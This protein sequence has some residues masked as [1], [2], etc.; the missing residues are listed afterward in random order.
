MASLTFPWWSAIHMNLVRLLRL[1]LLAA[2]PLVVFDF[3]CDRSP[4]PDSSGFHQGA[5]APAWFEDVTDKVGLDFVHDAGPTGNYFMPQVFGSGAA[6]FFDPHGRLYLYLLTN[7]GPESPSTNRLYRRRK[8]GTFEDVTAGSGLGIAG[9]NMGVAVGDVNNDGWPDVVVTQYGGLKLFLN[10]RDGTFR[11]VPAAESGLENP[12][13]ATSAAFADIDRDGWLDLVVVNYLDYDPEVPCHTAT[14]QRDFCLPGG[15]RGRVTKLFRNNG[16]KASGKKN[17]KLFQDITVSAGLADKPGPGLG[18]ICADFNGDGWP[19]IFVANDA[20]ANYLWIN[21]GK[22]THFSEEALTRGVALNASGQAQGNMGVALG[23]VDGDHLLDLFVTHFRT[24]YHTLWKQGP[25]GWFQDQSGAAGLTSTRWR[26]TG[27]GTA[28]V[29]FDH[30]GALDLAVVNGAVLRSLSPPAAPHLPAFWRP[31]AERNQLFANDGRGNFRDA[32]G[33]NEAF[34][35][36]PN[37][38]RGLVCG[39][40]DGDGAMD[41]LVTNVAGRARLYRNIA[42]KQGHWLMVRALLPARQGRRDAY[43]AEIRVEAG[44]R[45]RVGLINPGYSYLSSCDPRA[46]FGLGGTTH[47]DAIH[48]T[49]PDGFRESFPGG[50]V[51][52]VR[53]LG[54]GHGK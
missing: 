44:R 33:G 8:N 42:P 15:F 3:G 12:V 25:A 23:D 51:D 32:S 17:G 13:W 40:F 53:V 41:L 20:Q 9:H 7:G 45:T 22:G 30:D 1:A 5:P 2:V 36:T 27:F 50:P 35:G 49:W 47:V 48:V 37:L 39:D 14:G 6:M 34:C 16:G 26:G 18:I 46:H 21:N 31:Y 11:E 52:R 4:D 29:D 43:G 54:Q 10:N 28:L 38:G 19:D 24:E